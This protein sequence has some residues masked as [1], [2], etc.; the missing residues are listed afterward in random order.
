L[1]TVLKTEPNDLRALT[2]L[3][4]VESRTGDANAL[5]TFR[6]VVALDAHSFDAH[7]NLGIAL[8]DAGRS[9]EA[10]AEFSEAVRLA[11]DEAAPHYNKGRV[12]DQLHRY[13]EALPELQR[14]CTL[15]PASADA[16][17][18]LG[19]AQRELKQ[20]DEAVS[21]LRKALQLAP[22]NA[23]AS[24]LLGQSYQSLGKMDDAITAWRG[25]L[26]NDPNNQQALYSLVRALAK[27]DPAESARY[28]AR[29]ENLKGQRSQKEQAETLSNFAIAAAKENKWD[30]AIAQLR[31]AIQICGDCSSLA[32]LH[33][34]LGLIQCQAGRFADCGTELRVALGKMPGD[35]E[36]RK[37]LEILKSMGL[38]AR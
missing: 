29:L 15:D 10:L 32:Q 8:A 31:Q 20:Y 12:L 17:Y 36:I 27:R 13:G 30:D 19:I 38:A 3:G 16:W 37:A 34:N 18:R 9:E 1:E 5:T 26:H 7:L 33:K 21:A 11:P 22:G 2:A 25:A 35:P 23:D 14:A 24:Y 6:K 4:M 28:Q